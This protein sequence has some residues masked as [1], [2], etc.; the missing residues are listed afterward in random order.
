MSQTML[1]KAI[2]I[3]TRA[4]EEDKAKNYDEALKL[5]QNGVEHFLHAIKYEAQ[6][7]RSKAAIRDKCKQV[8]NLFFISSLI[9]RILN[10][11]K[12]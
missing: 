12:F 6:S 5:Y 3:V 2:E 4:T 1:Q 10:L 7:E 9:D 11:K 8:C